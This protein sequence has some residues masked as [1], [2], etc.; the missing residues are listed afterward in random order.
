M[1]ELAVTEVLA[2]VCGRVTSEGKGMSHNHIVKRGDFLGSYSGFASHCHY[3]LVT[4]RKSFNLSE[5]QFS[6]L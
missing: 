3:Q 2:Q 6:L 1:A 4:L 5:H